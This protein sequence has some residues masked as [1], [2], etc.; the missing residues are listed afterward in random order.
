MGNK[1]N[2]SFCLSVAIAVTS[3]TAAKAED[4]IE[5]LKAKG[6][7]E[8]GIAPE[9]PYA[10]IGADGLLTG[11]DPDIS[12]AVFKGLGVGDIKANSVDWGALIPGLIASRFDIVATG[13]FIRPERCKAVAFSQPLLCTREGFLVKKG[14]PLGLHSYDDLAPKNAKIS[15][16]GGGAEEKQALAKGV[17]RANLMSVSDIFNS[18]ELLK[19]G[20]VDVIAFPDVT[21]RAAME[22]AGGD[23]FELVSDLEGE[24]I[25]CAAAAFR[26]DDTALRDAYDEQIDK[27]KQSGQFDQILAKYSFDPKL[28]SA[29]NRDELC[30]AN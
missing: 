6:V 14:N 4:A 26:K 20:R 9:P 1:T 16:V 25:Q 5:R 27:L 15:T 23:D 10:I 30:K 17:S 22:R 11:A 21:L 2:I 28:A 18:V 8:I 13:L 19:S 12:R 3:L 7:V 24:P 29:T